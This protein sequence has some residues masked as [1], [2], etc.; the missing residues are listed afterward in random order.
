MLSNNRITI[1]V[2]AACPVCVT[3]F[4]IGGKFRLVS[5]STELHALTLATPA[6][7]GMRL[8]LTE[9]VQSSMVIYRHGYSVVVGSSYSLIPRPSHRPE[10][11]S[12][13]MN[14]LVSNMQVMHN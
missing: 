4:S 1:H 3:I 12:L 8:F 14:E 5:N 7:L 10:C 2:Y 6:R 11:N 9:I 13:S